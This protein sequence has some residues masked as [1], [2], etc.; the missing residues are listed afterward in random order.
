MKF[1]DES[2]LEKILPKNAD[3][4]IL[5]H[6]FLDVE[7]EAVY[8][9]NNTVVA[10]IPVVVAEDEQS[11]QV[12][13]EAIK[14]ARKSGK[15]ILCN[16]SVVVPEGATYHRG[17]ADKFPPVD[18]LLVDADDTMLFVSISAKQLYELAQA[19]GSEDVVLMLPKGMRR[20]GV[21]PDPSGKHISGARGVI[22]PKNVKSQG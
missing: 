2:K 12:N 7:R 16:E 8:A 14:M 20:I 5:L 6:P 3:V 18:D 10:K 11:G 19:L 9:S 22:I 17:P 13:I 21:V 1:P 4:P 15:D